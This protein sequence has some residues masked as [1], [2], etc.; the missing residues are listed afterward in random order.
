MEWADILEL[1]GLPFTSPHDYE[2]LYDTHNVGFRFYRFI[3]TDRHGRGSQKFCYSGKS[4]IPGEREPNKPPN[5]I[6]QVGAEK[7]PTDKYYLILE[8]SEISK[9]YKCTKFPG[10]CLY[11]TYNSGTFKK[12]LLACT[13]TPKIKS[14]QKCMG[15]NVTVRDEIIKAGTNIS[16][17]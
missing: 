1:F 17:I 12:H 9:D 10:K 5:F 14:V 13:D 15:K 2:K 7:W 6:I 8:R 16:Y 3:S 4:L 11:S